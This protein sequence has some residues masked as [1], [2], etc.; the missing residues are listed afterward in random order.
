MPCLLTLPPRSQWLTETF[1][2]L[3]QKPAVL[4]SSHLT[5]TPS[6]PMNP[7]DCK[8]SIPPPPWAEVAPFAWTLNLLVSLLPLLSPRVVSHPLV[9]SGLVPGPLPTDTKTTNAEVPY[10]K[11]CSICIKATGGYAYILPHLHGLNVVLDMWQI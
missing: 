6:A 3:R 11:W 10:V 7:A 5:P 4:F 8:T 9:S 2:L 1:S